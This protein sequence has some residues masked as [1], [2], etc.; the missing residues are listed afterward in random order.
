MSGCSP[1]F[2]GGQGQP[3]AESSHVTGMKAKKLA[4]HLKNKVPGAAQVFVQPLV[5]LVTDQEP[6][7]SGKSATQTVIVGSLIDRVRTDS[8]ALNNTDRCPI[9][10]SRPRCSRT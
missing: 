1:S 4:T 8:R 5:V 7:L 2:L 3:G 9:P 10:I 6:E